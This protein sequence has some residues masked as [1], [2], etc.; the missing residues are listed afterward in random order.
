MLYIYKYY[1]RVL[2]G[3][4]PSS[5]TKIA[6]YILIFSVCFSYFAAAFKNMIM[7]LLLLL[8]L[9]LLLL[10]LLQWLLATRCLARLVQNRIEFLNEP[11]I[12]LPALAAAGSRVDH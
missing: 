1:S 5:H 2:Q 4:L 9:L 8:W 7:N 12:L 11:L 10:L 6:F 3:I